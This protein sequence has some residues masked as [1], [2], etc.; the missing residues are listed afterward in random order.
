MTWL[1]KD[2]NSMY[3]LIGELYLIDPIRIKV[4]K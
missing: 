3:S 2:R 1:F 4:K